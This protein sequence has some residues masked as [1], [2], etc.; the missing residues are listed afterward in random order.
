MVSG[1]EGGY[2]EG[3]LELL[4]RLADIY[5]LAIHRKMEEDRLKASE[6]RNRAL[7]EK[8]LKIVTEVLE[9]IK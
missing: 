6:E 3:D 1:K 5:A 9:E 8:F 2:D 7:V 4:Q